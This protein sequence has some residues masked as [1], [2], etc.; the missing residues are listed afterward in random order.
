MRIV[1]SLLSLCAL[2]AAAPA[3]EEIRRDFQK[4]AA[5]ANG[6]SLR[7]EHSLGSVTVR[8]QAKNEVAVQA[9]IRCSADNAETARRFCDQIQIRVEE[10]GAGVIIRTDYPR[11]ET[12]NLSYSANLEIQMPETA[13]LE[14]RNRFGHVSVHKLRAP[15][16]IN[17]SNGNVLLMQTAG[18][19]RIENSFGNVEVAG[20]DGDVTIIN[21]NGWVRAGEIT[22]AADITNRFG[23]IRANN[24]GKTLTVRGGNSKVDVEHVGGIANITT[25]FGD[26]R[27]WDAKADLTVHNQN[28]RVEA[29]TVAGIADLQ[30]SF[31]SVKF[32]SIGKSVRVMA[33]NAAV[34]GDTVGESATVQTTFANVDL[35]GIKGGA[36]VTAANSGIRMVGIGGEAYAKTSFGGTTVEDVAGPVTVESA[37]GSVAVSPRAGQ[38]CKPV[39]IQTTFAPIRVGVIAG[40]GYTVTGKTSFGRIHSEPEMSITGAIAPES[41]T[42]KIAGGGCDL[43]LINQ[44]GNIDIVKR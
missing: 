29:A 2:A 9:A 34:N 44:N 22:G 40:V 42:G 21:G 20:N 19:Q 18:R 15:A 26:V 41:I 13:P 28:G 1:I 7:V 16:G 38:P 32:T 24:I 27:V 11:N 3:R 8:T 17:N 36:R 10:N 31:G 33:Q 43:R 37:N 39:A 35:R 30:T 23:E 5:L 14:L 6:R 12:R 4:T 25:T